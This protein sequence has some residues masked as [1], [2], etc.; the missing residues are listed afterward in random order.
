MCNQKALMN[1]GG[2]LHVGIA[3]VCLQSILD[4]QH[5]RKQ[6]APVL[7]VLTVC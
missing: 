4:H 1:H 5:K 7:L 2:A 3:S 6:E